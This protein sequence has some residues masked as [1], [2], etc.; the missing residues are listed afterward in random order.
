MKHV[1]SLKKI[2]PL[3]FLAANAFAGIAYA[4]SVR[5]PSEYNIQNGVGL[6][7]YDPVAVF[8]EGGGQA[9]V[10]QEQFKFEYLGVLYYFS[11]AQNLETFAQNPEKFEPSYGGWC[12]YAMAQGCKIDIDPAIFTIKGSRIHYF[13]SNRAKRNFDAAPDRQEAQADLNFEKMQ[14][15]NLKLG[16]CLP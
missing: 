16:E 6:K 5:N 4:E 10:G 11:S 15:L 12:A 1:I 14:G 9:Q 2:L 8:P 13:V 7:G 3:L